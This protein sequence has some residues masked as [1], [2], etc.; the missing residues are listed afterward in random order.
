VV[1]WSET[2]RY[3]TVERRGERGDAVM[4]LVN[5]EDE[6]ERIPFGESAG[7]WEL[8]LATNDVRFGVTSAGQAPPS[9]LEVSART[10]L[11]VPCPGPG[12]LI[13]A[14]NTARS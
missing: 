11:S 2:P 8:V 5:L 12:A 9:Q 13:Y 7:T 14:K 3:I 10:G 6:T 1:R 4:V